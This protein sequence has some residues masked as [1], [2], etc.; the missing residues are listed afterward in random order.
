MIIIF[1]GSIRRLNKIMPMTGRKKQRKKK[2]SKTKRSSKG[3][4]KLKQEGI[5]E[6]NAKGKK[7]KKILKEKL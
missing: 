6:H 2:K 4:E 1:K 5:S 7:R 3:S